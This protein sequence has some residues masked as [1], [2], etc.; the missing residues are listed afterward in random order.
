LRGQRGG[1]RTG[2]IFDAFGLFGTAVAGQ[3]DVVEEVKSRDAGLAS[4]AVGTDC[5]FVLAGLASLSLEIVALPATFASHVILTFR[6]KF[7]ARQTS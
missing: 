1:R 6:A 3:T 2:I 5:T 4:L 7:M